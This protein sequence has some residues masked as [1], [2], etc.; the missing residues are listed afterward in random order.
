MRNFKRKGLIII[1]MLPLFDMNGFEVYWRK[2]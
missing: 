2:P 1:K